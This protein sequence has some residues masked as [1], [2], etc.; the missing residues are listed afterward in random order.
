V[1]ER[2]TKGAFVLSINVTTQTS[3]VLLCLKNISGSGQRPVAGSCGH[4]N[5]PSGSIKGREFSL[6]AE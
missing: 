5:E 1:L 2:Q 6:L 3:G 4:G